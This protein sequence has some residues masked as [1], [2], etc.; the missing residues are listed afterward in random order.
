[1]G[2]QER[3]ILVPVLLHFSPFPPFPKFYSHMQSQAFPSHPPS[4]PPSLPL[5]LLPSLPATGPL[6]EGEVRTPS[7]PSSSCPPV[8][9]DMLSR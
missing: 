7:F 6:E 2:G 5:S 1:V 9:N 8:R 4:L 3:K